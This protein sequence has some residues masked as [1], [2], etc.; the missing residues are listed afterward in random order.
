M[1]SAMLPVKKS[2]FIVN[3]N[4]ILLSKA[5]IVKVTGEAPENADNK[6]IAYIDAGGCIG[7]MFDWW[8]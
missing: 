6:T 1:T 4:G 8:F 7:K 5:N 3:G 2:H